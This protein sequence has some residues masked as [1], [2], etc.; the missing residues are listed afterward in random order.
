MRSISVRRPR[1]S[2][3]RVVALAAAALTLFVALGFFGGLVP[4]FDTFG[5]FRAHG[6]ILLLVLVPPLLFQ[7][8]FGLGG[9]ACLVGLLAL[10]TVLPFLPLAT[11]PADPAPGAP[12]YTLLQM[13]LRFD[14][15]EPDKALSLIARLR[16]DVVTL[17]ELTGEWQTALE[18]MSS[19]YPYQFYCRSRKAD[20]DVAI[21]SRRPFLGSVP[22]REA[23]G[24]DC[25]LANRFAVKTVDFNG[26]PVVIGAEHLRW[27]WPGGQ[28]RMVASLAPLLGRLSDP[29][30]IAGDFNS[31][32]WTATMQAYAKASHTR[33]VGGIGPSWIAEFLPPELGRY[34]GLPIDNVLVSDGVEVLGVQRVEATSSDHLPVLLTFTMRFALPEEPE[35]RSATLR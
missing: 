15:P 8:R 6:A 16:P 10:Y 29:L 12:R 28:H 3:R 2:W 18:R 17:E 14:A 20:G 11:P 24:T 25:D 30:I 7:R 35:V 32:P 5:Q 23:T 19:A 33:L 21:L 1:L 31:A 34:L 27:P 26:L 22:G 4:L 9:A 13:N